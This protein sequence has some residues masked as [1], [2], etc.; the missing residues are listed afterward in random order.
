MWSNIT[1]TGTFASGDTAAA[2]TYG[3]IGVGTEAFASGD[4]AAAKTYSATIASDYRFQRLDGFEDGA[5]GVDFI[6]TVNNS[7]TWQVRDDRPID[8]STRSDI[9]SNPALQP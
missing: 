2:Q 7:A 9:T 8:I 4:T 1:S 3:S 5:G 6:L